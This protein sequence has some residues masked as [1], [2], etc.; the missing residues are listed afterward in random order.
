M[1][2]NVNVEILVDDGNTTTT[3]VYIFFTV[4]VM[5][6]VDPNRTYVRGYKKTTFHSA[7]VLYIACWTYFG[8]FVGHVALM[9]ILL[10]Y[11]YLKIKK[12]KKDN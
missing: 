2:S 12:I 8:S 11:N 1:F 6:Q 9:Y 7:H 4:F 10:R 5:F 3:R